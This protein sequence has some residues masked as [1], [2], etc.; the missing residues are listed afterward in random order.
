[1]AGI[2]YDESCFKTTAQLLQ[3]CVFCRASSQIYCLA[4][5]NTHSGFL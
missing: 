1:M 5:V 2:S 3:L 4:Y